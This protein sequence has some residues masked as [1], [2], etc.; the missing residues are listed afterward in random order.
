MEISKD[1]S[2]EVL[3]FII[4]NM[5][6][7][8]D[9]PNQQNKVITTKLANEMKEIFLNADNNSEELKKHINGY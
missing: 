4:D 1:T 6:E 2:L 7:L 8:L 3:T 5:T 9:D